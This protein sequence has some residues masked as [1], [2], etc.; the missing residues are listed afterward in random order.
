MSIINLLFKKKVI[1]EVVVPT[2]CY[3]TALKKFQDVVASSIAMTNARL[4]LTELSNIDTLIVSTSNRGAT[5]VELARDI[6]SSTIEL[7]MPDY[8][9]FAVFTL[10]KEHQTILLLTSLFALLSVLVIRYMPSDGFMTSSAS[11]KKKNESVRVIKK[12]HSMVTIGT[13]ATSSSSISNSSVSES[14]TQEEDAD[15][16]YEDGVCFIDDDA[17]CTSDIVRQ[18]ISEPSIIPSIIINYTVSDKHSSSKLKLSPMRKLSRK[19]SS[20]NRI[21]KLS[22]M[23][24]VGRSITLEVEE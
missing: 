15:T 9:S 19:L 2:K 11:Q 18:C 22:S 17:S 12:I 24:K 16:D 5:T 20:S 23:K 3:A 14:S 1:E 21:F 7:K 13:T 4:V 6:A 8:S 10:V